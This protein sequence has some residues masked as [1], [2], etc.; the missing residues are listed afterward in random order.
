MRHLLVFAISFLLA[1][2]TLPLIRKLAVKLD[3][4]DLPGRR[5]MHKQA[6]PLLGGIGIYLGVAATLLLDLKNLHYFLPVLIGATAI[7]IIGLVDDIRGLSAQFRL[8]CQLVIALTVIGLG[9]KISFLPHNLWGDIG[10][11][12]VTLLW[13][14]GV[15]NAYNY[16]DGL[17]GLAAGSAA[18]NLFCFSII[19]YTAG[20]YLLG[21]FC[22]ALIAGCSGFIPYNFSKNKIFLGDAGST[23]LGFSLSCIALMGNWAED[24]AAKL[25]IPILILGVPIF[26]MIF[27][28]I[29]RIKEMKV[30][31]F[32]G[33]LQYGGKDHFHHYLVALGLTPLGAVIFI[34]FVTLSLGL[35]AIMLSNDSALE[36]FLTI[37]QAAITFGVIAT[38]IIAGKRKRSSPEASFKNHPQDS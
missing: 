32:I 1:Y 12:V 38:L 8:F 9:L 24:G 15:T 14:I 19:L 4:M 17:D 2:F 30:K 10:E 29:M 25:S 13:I 27:T 5:K 21:L 20:Q 6:T 22:V 3:I 31:T 11:I 23:F 36:A 7:L 28:T 34:Y 16:L 37:L 35:S 18:V 33:W 26:D